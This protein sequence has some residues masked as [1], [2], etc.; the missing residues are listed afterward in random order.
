MMNRFGI[1][2]LPKRPGTL[3]DGIM[4]NRPELDD[5]DKDSRYVFQGMG[6]EEWISGEWLSLYPS[7][8]EWY[9]RNKPER[10]CS[11]FSA[12]RMPMLVFVNGISVGRHLSISIRHVFI[13]RRLL[14]WNP[15]RNLVT[16]RLINYGGAASSLINLLFSMGKIQSVCPAAG[17]SIRLWWYCTHQ[18]CLFS[19]CSYR[20]RPMISQS[21]LYRLRCGI[22]GE[23]NTAV[24]MN[25]RDVASHDY[26]LA[27]EL[28]DKELPLLAAGQFLMK[29]HPA[30][31]K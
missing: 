4:L 5:T 13:G 6:K 9:Q 19:D 3:H 16:V 20:Y 29:T 15:V 24:L 10:G 17:I 12:W 31:R 28:A 22:I 21:G 1:P 25:M 23:T 14:Y 27:W 7:E 18:Q 26:W 2:L 11:S 30:G 8:S